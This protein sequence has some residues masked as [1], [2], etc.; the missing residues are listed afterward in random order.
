[1]TPEQIEDLFIRSFDD[2]L[3]EEEKKGLLKGLHTET[4]LATDLSQYKSI[5]VAIRRK[6]PTSFG[7][8]FAQKVINK[9]QNLGVEIDKQIGAFFKKYQ[10]AVIGVLIALLAVNALFSD[11]LN[12]SSL[13]GIEDDPTTEIVSFDFFQNLND[14]L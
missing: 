6:N 2:A 9:I 14:A 1:M 13:F 7:P 3:S 5:R 12:I 4:G 10:L 11:Q 8:F